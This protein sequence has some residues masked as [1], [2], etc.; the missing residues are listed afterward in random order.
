[1]ANTAADIQKLYI[2]YFNRPADAAGLKYWMD[3]SMSVKDIAKSFGVQDEYKA[4]F[5]GQT[6]E[7]II[8]TLYKNLFGADRVVDAAGLLYWV[9]QVQ[10]GKSTIADVAINIVSGATTGTD[11]AS[12]AAKVTAATAFTNALDLGTEIVAYVK[13]AGMT[14]GKA[15]LSAVTTDVSAAAQIAKLDATPTLL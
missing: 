6:T 8:S 15:W 13:P 12:I 1:M 2:A 14:A 7:S 4:A 11:A 5:A 10:S 9:G 3:S